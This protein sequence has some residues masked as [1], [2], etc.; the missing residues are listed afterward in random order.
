MLTRRATLAGLAVLGL[1]LPARA[2]GF[3]NRAVTIIVPYTPAG[4]IDIMA[5]LVAQEVAPELRQS[6]VVENR[7]G[8]SG[9]IGS[10][11]VARAEPDGYTLVFG[12]SQTHV[13]NQSMIKNCP[14][15]AV[16]DFAPVAGITITPH[17]LVVRKDLPATS[18][19][20]FIALAKARPGALTFGTIGPGSSAHLSTELFKLKAGIDM[21]HVPFKG[22]A[23]LTTELLAGRI[24]LSIAPLPGLIQK[25]V[26]SG[27]IRPLALA[28]AKRTEFLPSLPTFAEAGVAGVE[29]DAFGALFAPAR[30]PP[31]VIDRLYQAVAVAVT[32]ESL[33][34]SAARQG[35]PIALKTP[36]EISATLPGEIAKWADVIKLAQIPLE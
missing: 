16:K 15:D 11:A 24:D 17:V 18:L 5:R 36:A 34:T 12:T 27:S 19:G 26:E 30:T 33:V 32:K 13:T 22:L 28:S 21:L 14:Y 29:A 10:N 6:V 23:P 31:P 9:I 1:P 3:P 25:Q 7:P 20:E 4:P 8:G 2:Q 35:I